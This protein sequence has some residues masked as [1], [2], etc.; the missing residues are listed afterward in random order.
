MKYDVSTRLL[1]PECDTD[2]HVGTAGPA[3]LKQHQ[4][5]GPC[6]AARQ[7]RDQ[8]KKT[9]T[10]FDFPLKQGKKDAATSNLVAES[11]LPKTQLAFPAP[12]IVHPLVGPASVPDHHKLLDLQ[13]RVRK[14]CTLGW[15]LID[16]LRMAAE[17]MGPDI[18]TARADDEISGFGRAQAEAQCAG[19]ADDEIWETVNPGLDR[20]LGFGRSSDD[21]ALA[22]RGGE[23]G[24]KGFCDYL[25]YLVEEKGIGG[26]LLEGK[27]KVLIDALNKLYGIFSCIKTLI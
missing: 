3:G 18:P 20:L 24:V 12:I 27:V 13:T 4:G 19:V 17:N 5:M 26:G 1:C 9:R 7:K 6:R 2:V 10:L 22:V 23:M 14:G 8:Q 15:K 21:V 25:S 16:E 11:S